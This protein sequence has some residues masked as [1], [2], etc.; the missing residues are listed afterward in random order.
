MSR[1]P[2]VAVKLLNP[3][4]RRPAGRAVAPTFQPMNREF[5]ARFTVILLTILTVAAVV[6]A[7]YNYRIEHQS[8]IPDDGA[9]WLERHGQI[10]ADRL[11]PGGPPAAGGLPK[12]GL[13][14]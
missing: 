13:G 2:N 6:F 11:Y 3:D 14:V 5:Q 9:W 1:V 12:R 7:G 4:R 8:A 10:V